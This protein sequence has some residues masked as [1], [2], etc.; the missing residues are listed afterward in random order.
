MRPKGLST[1]NRAISPGPLPAGAPSEPGSES[2]AELR[3]SGSGWYGYFVKSPDSF[4][5]RAAWALLCLLV[6]S[7]PMEKGIQFAH[8][9][10]ISRVLGQAAFLVGAAA[11]VR[12]RNLRKPN[13]ALPLAAVFVL[14]GGLSWGWSVARPETLTRFITMAQ[15]V[16]MAWLIWELC[17][18][19]AAQIRL[20][21]AFVAGAAVSSAWT[22]MR[23]ALNRQTNYRR[24]A[25][26]GFDPND[27]GIT[28][29]IA[30]TF[31]LYL[32]TRVRGLAVWVVRLAT[33]PIV[34]AILLTAS[35]AA[36]VAAL[37]NFVFVVLAWRHT[38]VSQRLSS[39]T[40]LLLLIAG[41]VR[42]AP[43]AT[44]AR[45]ATLPNEATE[46]TLHDRTRIWKAGLRLFKQHPVLGIGLGAY[47]K[48]AYPVLRI[49][50]NAHNT[51]LSVL[52][53]TGMIG[54][55]LWG[56]LLATLI[57]F[58]GLLAASERA[59]WFTALAV[60][61][62]AVLTVTWEHRK[63]TWLIFALIMTAWARAFQPEDR[64]P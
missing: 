9:G 38:T 22:I 51:F 17:R 15:L 3:P 36:L 18:T 20:I 27:L 47:P 52:V 24:Y 23:A 41:T 16:G 49:H 45:L 34:A 37:M 10:T 39:L 14:W 61:G 40:L 55:V 13:A 48:A 7:L 30:L 1:N 57:W 2:G 44:R 62:V 26:T 54:F 6:F 64:T 25:T 60:W 35:R 58:A 42:L 50:Y 8:L 4:L 33:V 43:A 21:Q 59:M 19:G 46:G 5:E 12:R 53:E 56:L 31:A 63:P 11:V 29:A 32:S 28:L